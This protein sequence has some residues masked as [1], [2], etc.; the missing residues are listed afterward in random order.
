MIK[1]KNL[2]QTN[3]LLE[4]NNSLILQYKLS[5]ASALANTNIL[6]SGIT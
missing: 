5:A 3:Y 4:L 2:L 1:L 6:R